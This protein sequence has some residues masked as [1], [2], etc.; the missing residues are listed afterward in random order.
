MVGG[1]GVRAL[2]DDDGVWCIRFDRPKTRVARMGFTHA[3]QGRY[4][5]FRIPKALD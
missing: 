2:H 4:S 1:D 3:M 5:L